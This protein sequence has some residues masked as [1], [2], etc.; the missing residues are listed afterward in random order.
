MEGRKI[1]EIGRSTRGMYIRNVADITPNWN[2]IRN[3]SDI[4]ELDEM[5]VALRYPYQYSVI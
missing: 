4:N 2:D 3:G 5:F 1:G